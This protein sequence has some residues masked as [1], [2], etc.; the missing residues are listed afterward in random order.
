MNQSIYFQKASLKSYI[1]LQFLV[2]VTLFIFGL[3]EGALSTLD[4]F[5]FSTP[6]ISFAIYFVLFI[7]YPV[8]LPI[9]SIFMVT[10][11]LNLDL[12]NLAASQT[13]AVIV[14]LLIATR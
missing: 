3:F 12:N 8:A 6:W 4:L 14:S 7:F 5:L 9:L 13:F 2:T 1:S 10:F 11:L